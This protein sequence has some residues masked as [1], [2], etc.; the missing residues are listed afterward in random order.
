MVQEY[1]DLEA[2]LEDPFEPEP[3]EATLVDTFEPESTEVN[4]FENQYGLGIEEQYLVDPVRLEVEEA[5]KEVRGPAKEEEPA[6]EI[7]LLIFQPGEDL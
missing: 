6:P 7:T 3:T 1:S 5:I 2:I 4:M